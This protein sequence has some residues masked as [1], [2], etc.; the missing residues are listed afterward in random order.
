MSTSR[1]TRFFRKSREFAIYILG[2]ILAFSVLLLFLLFQLANRFSTDLAPNIASEVIGIIVTVVIID[3]I[4][5]R[6]EKNRYA[7]NT[8]EIS[9]RLGDQVGNMLKYWEGWFKEISK[10]EPEHRI[11]KVPSRS[12]NTPSSLRRLLELVEKS[13]L[14]YTEENLGRPLGTKLIKDSKSEF[15]KTSWDIHRIERPLENYLLGLEI[16]LEPTQR[17]F[18]R[19]NDELKELEGKATRYPNLLNPDIQYLILRQSRYVE[20]LLKIDKTF[21]SDRNKQKQNTT[22]MIVEVV[23]ML[24]IL[25][26]LLRDSLHLEKRY[27]R[28]MSDIAY[29]IHEHMRFIVII[30]SLIVGIILGMTNSSLFRFID[31]FVINALNSISGGVLSNILDGFV[32][33]FLHGTINFF[34][35]AAL[36]L[37]IAWMYIIIVVIIEDT[38]NQ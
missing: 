6:R 21:L 27:I 12:K 23:S 22:A 7:K 24:L 2:G 16:P 32:V 11:K 17:L 19:L 10:E 26:K 28:V 38:E 14:A 35:T 3:S 18:V 30:P 34:I 31:D 25:Q 33:N 37:G 5:K 9:T 4:L 1:Y 13:D 8:A 29:F 15:P 20:G 36:I